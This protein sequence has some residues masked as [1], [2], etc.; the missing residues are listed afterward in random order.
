MGGDE[1]TSPS[2]PAQGGGEAKRPNPRPDV[3]FTPVSNGIDYLFS[4]FQH[5]TEGS[6]PPSARD[7]KYTVL[8]LQAATEVL[9]KARL[10]YEHFSLIFADPTQATHDAWEK[11]EF[12]SC[13][14]LDAV[15]RLRNI[16]PI[17]IS[18][19]DRTRVKDLGETRNALQHYGLHLNAFAMEARAVKVLDFLLT[20]IHKHLL[21]SLKDEADEVQEAMEVFRQKL[22]GIETLVRQRMNSLRSELA[23]VTDTTVQCPDCGQMALVADGA[24]DGPTCLFCYQVRDAEGAARDY[25]WMVLGHD[26]HTAVSEGWSTMPVIDCPEC[27]SS[28]LV[29]DAVTAASGP[30][31][32]GLCFA[33]GTAF[34]HLV[35]C[36]GGCGEA[37]NIKPDGESILMCSNC[38]DIRMARF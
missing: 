37:L 5:L 29:P 3:S 13:S 11:G 26:E 12:K 30:Q 9:L 18:D 25:A 32:T 1:R 10:R 35:D 36:E 8:H 19:E 4:V 16:V 15:D 21:P 34:E 28:A 27:N 33:C 24:D 38:I 31:T 20:F 6:T 14:T 2:V 22:R 7:L 17:K 23:E